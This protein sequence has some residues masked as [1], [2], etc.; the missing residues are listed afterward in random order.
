MRSTRLLL[1]A[2]AAA[3]LWS[4]AGAAADTACPEHFWHGTAPVLT[5]PKL[6]S[7]T[8]ELCYSGYAVLHSGLT[9]TPLWSAE[10]LTRDRVA[11]ARDLSRVNAFHPDPNL[12][13]DERSD[14]S[15]YARSGF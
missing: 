14:L 12:P 7:R 15:D 3:C 1:A 4:G 6:E 9:R 2:Y 10:H 5:N 11:A 13:A 8:R